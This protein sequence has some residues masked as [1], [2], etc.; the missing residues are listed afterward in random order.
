[1]KRHTSRL[2]QQQKAHSN[3]RWVCIL[4]CLLLSAVLLPPRISQCPLLSRKIAST[5]K[6]RLKIF[7]P[8][9]DTTATAAAAPLSVEHALTCIIFELIV[10]IILFCAIMVIILRARNVMNEVKEKIDTLKERGPGA[11]M[12]CPSNQRLPRASTTS[13]RYLS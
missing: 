8:K 13:H 12:S 11:D 9:M 4:P 10:I 2:L 6:M 5:T 1:M 3:A 7:S